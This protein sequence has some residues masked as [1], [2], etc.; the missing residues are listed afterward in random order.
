MTIFRRLTVRYI[1]LLVAVIALSGVVIFNIVRERLIFNLDATLADTAEMVSQNSPFNSV[2]PYNSKRPGSNAS[3]PGV[4]YAPGV[5]VQT[6]ELVDGAL[7]IQGSSP[8]LS[9]SLDAAALGD[10]RE[11]YHTITINGLNLRVYTQPVIQDGQLIG[12]IQV[13]GDLATVNQTTNWLMR[14]MLLTYGALIVGVGVL[15]LRFSQRTLR[16]I[17]DIAGIANSI[18]AA[19]DLKSRLDWD[20]PT[21][22]MGHLTHVF[23]EAHITD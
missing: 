4:L 15:S 6:W 20:G 3:S 12:S 14:A 8:E 7:A 21:R 23:T 2:N 10:H 17:R 22:E 16:P 9:G 18:T 5:Y 19:N 13:A 1:I 11:R